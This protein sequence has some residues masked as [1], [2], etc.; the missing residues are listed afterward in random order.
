MANRADNAAT[1]G[2][3]GELPT[4]RLVEAVGEENLHASGAL[5]AESLVGT[6]SS[7]RPAWQ[8]ARALLQEDAPPQG[9]VEIVSVDSGATVGRLDRGDLLRAALRLGLGEVSSPTPRPLGLGLEFLK[10]RRRPFELDAHDVYGRIQYGWTAGE[11]A[12][13]LSIE[14]EAYSTDTPPRWLGW[15]DEGQRQLHEVPPLSP[16]GGSRDL[17]TQ[18]RRRFEAHPITGLL[19]STAHLLTASIEPLGPATV[20]AE[21]ARFL[22][23]EGLA[24]ALS[25]WLSDEAA[26]ADGEQASRMEH[27]ARVGLM[28]ALGLSDLAGLDLPERHLDWGRFGKVE[29]PLAPHQLGQQTFEAHDFEQAWRRYL[30]DLAML[31]ATGVGAPAAI[32]RPRFAALRTPEPAAPPVAGEPLNEGTLRKI[33]PA[34]LGVRLETLAPW[35]SDVLGGRLPRSGVAEDEEPRLDGPNVWVQGLLILSCAPHAQE[36]ELLEI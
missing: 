17:S 29:P 21:A 24:R 9:F 6:L 34:L 26:V 4:E 28:M 30:V 23:F 16:V 19:P 33:A 3:L 13:V 18:L 1:K 27:L 25:A 8:V 32:W 20:C 22:S 15:A 14:S 31:L 36:L 7:A 2:A 12:L 5:G 11:E 10:V 35:L